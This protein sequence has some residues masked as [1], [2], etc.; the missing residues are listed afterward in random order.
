MVVLLALSFECHF[1]QASP[2]GPP[3]LTTN[4]PA[5]NMLKLD[6]ARGL[7]HSASGGIGVSLNWL[8]PMLN[9]MFNIFIIIP[10]QMNK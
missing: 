1:A 3:G 8:V 6:Q 4:D 2:S 7:Q 10:G 9:R 5:T